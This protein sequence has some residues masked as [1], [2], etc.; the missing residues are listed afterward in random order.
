MRA[1]VHVF[2]DALCMSHFIHL[3][4]KAL[5]VSESCYIIL[6]S[7]HAL[8]QKAGLPLCVCLQFIS[9]ART[10]ARAH[11]PP[12]SLFHT[13]VYKACCSQTALHHRCVSNTVL[14]R[15]PPPALFF[16]GMKV[17]R[18]ELTNNCI[19]SSYLGQ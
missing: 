1:C 15:F 2:I 17:T 6:L 19:T 10:R 8:Q 3:S 14:V 11:L 16:S 7:W 18:G 9:T 13:V 12:P 4:S 5:W